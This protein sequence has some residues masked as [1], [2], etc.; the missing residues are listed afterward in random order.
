MKDKCADSQVLDNLKFT[1]DYSLKEITV[2][3]GA[4]TASTLIDICDLNGNVLISGKFENEVVIFSIA[5]L[6]PG[7]YGICVVDGDIMG[8]RK[9]SIDKH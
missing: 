3:Y 2:M 8:M 6:K 4:L 9:F 1:I 5:N 7:C